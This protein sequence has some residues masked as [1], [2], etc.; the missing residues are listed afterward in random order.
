MKPLHSLPR[1]TVDGLS[2]PDS[3][4]L[5]AVKVSQCLN[6][7]SQ[8][9]VTWHSA[10][11]DPEVLES[12]QPPP[13]ST[14]KVMLDEQPA[15]LFLGEVGG[16]EYEHQPSG[17]LHIHVRAYD[18]MIVLQRQQTR[19]TQ[20]DVTMAD[21]LRTLVERGELSVSSAASGGP[22]WPRVIQR[23]P[24]DLALLRHYGARCGLHFYCEEDGV[25]LFSLEREG[26][27]A[28]PLTLGHN[29][30]ECR[31]E[32]NATRPLSGVDVMAWNC[33]TGESQS[34]QSESGGRTEP[35]SRREVLGTLFESQGEVEARANAHW[36]RHAMEREVFW[37]V[38]EGHVD[39]KPGAAV[40]VNGV[41]GGLSGNYVLTRATHRIDAESGYLTE[42]SSRLEPVEPEPPAPGLVTG[43]VRDVDDPQERGRVQVVMPSYGDAAGTWMLVL[44]LGAGE[45]KG[46]VSLPEVGDRV[47]VA[48]PDNDP[49][50]GLVLGGLY[51]E[52]GPP[53][54]SGKSGREQ[55]FP[56]IL[57]TRGGQRLRLHDKDNSI[58]LEN[59]NGSY[60]S[61]TP[62]GIELHAEGDLI[63]EAPGQSMRLT[64][65]QIDFR[66]G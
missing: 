20:V 23:F 33:H 42:V 3:L 4:R 62:S 56:Y 27:G 19:E 1:I 12:A 14:L 21:L 50:R 39:Y 41:A 16:V 2:L 51:G 52:A 36:Q 29:L 59:A 47:L 66:R 25:R 34:G 43:E 7:P 35:G 40:A 8:C 48:L 53:L 65:D 6:A 11:P 24:H 26:D 10:T 37:G 15:P 46:L 9:V 18:P 28:L 60:L 57:K 32:Q 54:E 17:A 55:H 58:R 61:L 31:L 13:G 63:L 38:V 30:L 22:V 44:Q 49:S 45:E 5:S 64:G